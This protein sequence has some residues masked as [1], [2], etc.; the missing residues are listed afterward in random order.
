MKVMSIILQYLLDASFDLLVYN[1]DHIENYSILK[2]IAPFVDL[3]INSVPLE[4][5]HITLYYKVKH[6]EFSSNNCRDLDNQT[7][8]LQYLFE[9]YYIWKELDQ[10]EWYGAG[11]GIS[12]PYKEYSDITATLAAMLCV[13]NRAEEG[14]LYAQESIR[15]VKKLW[16][17]DINEIDINVSDITILSLI[18]KYIIAGECAKRCSVTQSFVNLYSNKAF[19][20]LSKLINSSSDLTLKELNNFNNS[21]NNLKIPIDIFDTNCT[22]NKKR[23]WLK[24]K[25]KKKN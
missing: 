21:L 9:S 13:N 19:N 4:A 3:F 12:N 20:L 17:D 23:K 2:F 8:Q 6:R 18:N 15:L 14:L 16:I 24:K 25:E 5:K 22:N 1:S 11:N 7:C 10:L